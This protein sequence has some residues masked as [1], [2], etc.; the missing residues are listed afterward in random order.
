[1]A[2]VN[3]RSNT[4]RLMCPLVLLLMCVAAFR[5][6]PT[7]GPEGDATAECDGRGAADQVALERCLSTQPDNVEV[8]TVLGDI[9]ESSG[10]AA[11]AEALYRRVLAIDPSDGDV[12]V[13]LGTLL[14]ARGDAAGARR[15]AGEALRWQPGSPFAQAILNRAAGT[16]TG[17]GR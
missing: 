12:H 16:G 14:I 3:T 15:E 17:I 8:M 11:R 4:F 5:A 2:G 9:E 1:M 7:S 6:T 13:R 10:H